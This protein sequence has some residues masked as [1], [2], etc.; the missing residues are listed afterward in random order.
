MRIHGNLVF[1]CTNLFTATAIYIDDTGKPASGKT[2]VAWP[3]APDAIAYSYPYVISLHAAKQ[4]MEIR[5]P[6]TQTL[7]QTIPIPGVTILHVPP[8]GVSL[9]HAGRLFYV[10]SPTHVYKMGTVDY[11]TQVNQLVDAGQLDEAISLLEQLESVLLD[12]KEERIREIRM[13]KAETLFRKRKFKDSMELFDS[14]SAPPERVIRLYPKSIAGDLAVLDEE[15]AHSVHGETEE[16]KED[17]RDGEESKSES[18]GEEAAS[19]GDKTS[20]KEARNEVSKGEDVEDEVEPEGIDN[21]SAPTTIV[22][23]ESQTAAVTEAPVRKSVDTASIFSGRSKMT[24][25]SDATRDGVIDNKPLGKY[26]RRRFAFQLLTCCRRQGSH[27][28]RKRAHN[29]PRRYSSPVVEVP[30]S[31]RPSKASPRCS[32]LTRY[33]NWCFKRSLRH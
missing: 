1:S 9:S 29:I 31:K 19:E 18:E 3:V 27:T 15:Q 6:A 17:K 28:L 14:L 13:L 30:R 32:T 4:Q 2:T 12:S 21:A 22:E 33:P 24:L 16:L 25:T 10:A 5:N 20:V 8:P 7:I 26:P 11:E 23:G